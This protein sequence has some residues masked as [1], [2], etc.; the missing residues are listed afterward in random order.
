[1]GGDEKDVIER[2]RLLNHSHS[3]N[4]LNQIRIIRRLPS[5]GKSF[6][7]LEFFMPRKLIA[8]LLVCAALPAVGQS[9]YSWKDSSGQVHYSDTPPPEMKA[10]DPFST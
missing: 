6:V 9:I 8:A 7:L 4:P 10:F 3:F 5:P 2:Q 1:M